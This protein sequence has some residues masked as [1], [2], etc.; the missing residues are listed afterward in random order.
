M[1]EWKPNPQL[2]CLCTP[3][4]EPALFFQEAEATRAWAPVAEGNPA[5][6]AFTAID[7]SSTIS[8]EGVYFGGVLGRNNKLY[9]VPQRAD[10]IG[11][12]ELGNTDP[13]YEVACCIPEAW[14]SLLSPHFN[15]F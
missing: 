7:I 11:V 14:S 3:L 13:V 5:T 9:A 2:H 4:T 6:Q 8:G 15:K 10:K 1:N 12:L